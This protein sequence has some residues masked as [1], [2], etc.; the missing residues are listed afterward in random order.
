MAS[1][2]G[3]DPRGHAR[4]IT[5]H[6]GLR[7]RASLLAL[8]RAF[9]AQ[10]QVLELETPVLS[11]AGNSDP[12]ISQF[13]TRCQR[14]LRTSPEYAMKRLIANGLGDCYELG[15]V[16]RAGEAGAWHNPE[17]TLLEWYR[18]GWS[19][20]ELMLEVS[21]LVNFCGADFSRHW[22]VR[23]L[24]YRDWLWEAL[25][26]DPLKAETHD[27]RN[28]IDHHGITVQG[29]ETLDR[30]GLLDVL[31]SHIVQPAM[32]TDTLT[33]VSLYPASQAALAQLHEPDPRLAERFEAYLGPVELA[34]GY[35]E[36]TDPAEQRR[37]FETENLK[38]EAAGLTVVPLDEALLTALEAGLPRCTGVALGV[39]RLL[40]TMTG[41][42]NIRDSLALPWELA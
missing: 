14:W 23:Q 33:L 27:L 34:N 10:R 35:Q 7:Q 32:D 41:A 29:L 24:S 5:Q 39:D 20:T 12:G 42:N 16:F 11:R 1:G 22:T 25:E 6:E 8:L 9:F 21:D 28:V 37:R 19:Y 40:A 17:F 36:L 13:E 26:V 15:R 31:I 4:G 2:S 38:R 18:V 30:D 3:S